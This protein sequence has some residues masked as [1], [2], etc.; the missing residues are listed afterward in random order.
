MPMNNG[1]FVG[2]PW[3]LASGCSVSLSSDGSILAV[4][5]PYDDNWIGATWVYS[6]TDGAYNQMGEKLVCTDYVLR[7]RQGKVAGVYFLC[8]LML[9]DGWGNL[10]LYVMIHSGWSVSL[11]SDGEILAVGAPSDDDDIGATSIFHYNGSTYNQLGDK[12]VGE[13]YVFPPRQG[14][15][16]KRLHCVLWNRGR[17]LPYTL[18]V[19][20]LLSL[21]L[22]F[23][24]FFFFV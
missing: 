10:S 3:C 6:L 13:G 4:G 15:K 24:F 21:F 17:R 1:H 9:L 11:S 8:T 22:Y 19:G 2:S 20:L 14:K 23:P 5:A 12:L 18:I 16:V 7:P